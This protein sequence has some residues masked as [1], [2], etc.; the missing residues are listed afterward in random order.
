MAILDAHILDDLHW[1]GD[2]LG[3][4]SEVAAEAGLGG[5]LWCSAADASSCRHEVGEYRDGKVRLHGLPG[6]GG[7]RLE[8]LFERLARSVVFDTPRPIEC[9]DLPAGD[10]LVAAVESKWTPM[11]ALT[12]IDPDL[13]GWAGILLDRI[14]DP[15]SIWCFGLLCT[16]SAG[17]MHRLDEADGGERWISAEPELLGAALE[18]CLR[19]DRTAWTLAGDPLCRSYSASQIADLVA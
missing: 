1:H 17:T 8:R 12:R 9:R 11:R 13:E 15:C 4:P 6:S 16:L 5:C 3:E 7:L 14:G 10:R 18:G 19:G 2:G